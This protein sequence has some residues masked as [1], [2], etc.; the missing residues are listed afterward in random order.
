M[1]LALGVDTFGLS[2]GGA[3]AAVEEVRSLVKDI[4]IPSLREMGITEKM[5][6]CWPRKF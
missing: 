2:M 1:A 6:L 5:S 3:L 4:G